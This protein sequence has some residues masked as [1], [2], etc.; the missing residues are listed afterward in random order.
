MQRPNSRIAVTSVAFLLIAASAL[1][2][3]TGARYGQTLA[4]YAALAPAEQQAWLRNL[5]VERSGAGGTRDAGRR[6][7]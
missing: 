5:V 4:E 1:A 7:L 3:E 6:R 2:A